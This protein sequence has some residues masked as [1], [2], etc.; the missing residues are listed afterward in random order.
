MIHSQ[1]GIVLVLDDWTLFSRSFAK[2]DRRQQVISK[3]RKP[4]DTFCVQN[5][6][7]KGNY[8]GP[9]SISVDWALSEE[10]ITF[11]GAGIF[12]YLNF[13]STGSPGEFISLSFSEVRVKGGIP[14][15]D[16][17]V[18]VSGGEIVILQTN[19]KIWGN[20]V[21]YWG[22]DPYKVPNVELSLDKNYDGVSPEINYYEITNEYGFF[23][24]DLFL[25]TN[26]YK[27]KINS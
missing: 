8:D 2:S 24:F 11:Q 27:I 20:V 6:L 4:S 15:N 18:P 16:I 10:E 1:T 12:T 25:F 5:P 17:S 13:K 3:F 22:D 19:Y 21:Y 26:I 14:E 7:L 9:D 23:E